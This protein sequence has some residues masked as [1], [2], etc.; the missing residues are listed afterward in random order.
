MLRLDPRRA[1]AIARPTA[2]TFTVRP[3]GSQYPILYMATPRMP[4][5]VGTSHLEAFCFAR[6]EIVIS[7]LKDKKPIAVPVYGWT[8]NEDSF[9]DR[10]KNEWTDGLPVCKFG[11]GGELLFLIPPSLKFIELRLILGILTS[12]EWHILVV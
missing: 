1:L 2:W 7:A 8:C 5:S 12:R 10:C 4:C 3:S 6:Q 11:D 9:L